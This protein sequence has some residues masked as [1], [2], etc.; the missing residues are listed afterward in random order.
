M[1]GILRLVI[2]SGGAFAAGVMYQWAGA[3][4]ACKEAGGTM[5]SGICRGVAANG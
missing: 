2:F 5:Q 3:A 1:F 4:E